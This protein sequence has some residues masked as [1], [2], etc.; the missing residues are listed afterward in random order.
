MKKLILLPSLLLSLVTLAQP[1][2]NNCTGAIV[3]SPSASCVSVSG[4]T[5]GASQ[6]QPGCAGSASD[7]VWYTFT[8]NSTA[9]SV[10]VIGSSTFNAVV[11]LFSGSCGGTS[12]ACVNATGNGGT[13]TITNT[14]LVVG[15]QYWIRVHHFTSSASSNPTFAICVTAPLVEPP[16]DP[17]S[18][19]P[20]NSSVPCLSVPKICRLNGFCGTTQ[21]YH[22]TPT[23]TV[24]TPYSV[25]TWPQLSTAF[26]GS[27]ENN[28]FM[29]FEASATT[30]QLRIYGSC[31]SGTGI[32]MLAFSYVNPTNCGSGAVTSYG[33]TSPLTFPS[34]VAGI[35][36]TFTG[37]VP[38]Q[39]YYL[40]VDGYAGAIC[41]YKIGADFGVQ[42]SATVL[43]GN[44]AMCL[45][46]S[47]NL[48]ASGGNGTYT[49]D[50]DPTLSALIGSNVV[51]TPT[52]I[53]NYTYVVNS[54][55]TDPACPGST[56]TSFVTVGA[57]PT[58]N[59][60]FN[61]SVCLGQPISLTGTLSNTA[62]T[63]QWEYIPPSTGPTPNVIFGPNAN[64]SN[65][66]VSVDQPGLYKFIF[67]ETNSICGPFRDTIDVWVLDPQLTISSVEPSCFG[68]SDGTITITS[69]EAIDYSFDN[70]TSWQASNTVVNY[71][72]GSFDVCVRDILGCVSCDTIIVPVPPNVL[73]SVSN[74]TIICENGT[75]T[76]SAQ[77]SFG[78]SF[79]Y[80]WS[81]TIDLSASQP[82]SPTAANYY[83]VYAENQDGCLSELDS[84]F[85]D[86]LPPLSGTITPD[87]VICPSD[88]AVITATAAGGN[89]GPYLFNWSSGTS[90]AGMTHSITES[91]VITTYY[92]VEISDGCE[93]TPQLYDMTLTVSPVPNPM[94]S[95]LQD[96]ICENAVFELYNTT[97]PLMVQTS[98][99]Q[100]SDGQVYTNMDTI[101][102][103]QMSDGNYAV[104][105]TII[106]PDGCVNTTI[107][108]NALR[109]MPRP[110]ANFRYSPATIT[111]LNTTV[112]ME[113]LSIGNDISNW[114]MQY[115]NPGA[116]N[117]S[118]PTV[119]F[120]E[121]VV[122][123]YIV[124]LIA[125]TNFGCTDTMYQVIEIKPEVIL[126]SPNTFTPD[127][128]E[129][130]AT[131]KIFIEGIDVSE[132]ELKVYNRW[133][134][135][136]WQSYDPSAE[137]D[138]TYKGEIVSS[139]S[140]NWTIRAKDAN[141]S[142]NHTWRGNVLLLK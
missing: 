90:G 46:S 86:V 20:S 79:S 2:N 10:I 81:Q 44:T 80:H 59:A 95:I 83:Y 7:D 115:A 93:S 63:A 133:G 9:L 19:E 52:A 33:C 8:A 109:S 22:A 29:R 126:Y 87:F 134:E 70:G 62:N 111:A 55:S 124:Q 74:D 36:L 41:N 38:G 37:M 131:W 125:E 61:D 3:L 73:I 43:P 116:S 137:W 84:I 26:C 17:N 1:S 139:G 98:L 49:W 77:G 50:P 47:L 39:I 104:S 94:F 23:A 138:G 68:Y 92:Q 78:I 140:Y 89:N 108:N 122:D 127:N 6:S 40:M 58:P 30:V 88:N 18:P 76:I 4:T 105:L 45:G 141:S 106:S 48:S 67:K 51:A 121:G 135:I 65:V 102:T 69:S 75:A 28:S 112:K 142:E 130:N 123:N 100:I 129:F 5:A 54:P 82:I 35:P 60:G 21:G 119:V 32:Q 85:I 72:S 99:W 13:E 31:T 120:P 27:I 101:N 136:V 114:T 110:T 53:G 128:D 14:S 103:G 96:S 118:E 113:N 15:T 107:L 91:P 56:D 64:T 97:D 16:C 12:L 66:T 25:N 42:V 34:P 57:Q 117:T 11:Q 24:L 132:F 71:P